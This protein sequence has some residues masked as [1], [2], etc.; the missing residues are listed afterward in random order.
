MD[1]TARRRAARRPALPEI[2]LGAGVA[3]AAV[4]ALWQASVIPVSPLYA[5]VGPTVFPYIGAVLLGILGLSLVYQGLRGGWQLPDEKEVPLDWRAMGVVGA[6]LLANVVMIQPLGF[7][8]ASTVMFTLIA[9][10]FGSRRPWIDAPIGLVLALAAYF[11]FAQG[12][13]VNIGRGPFE[14]ALQSA[15]GL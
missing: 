1:G 12:L 13:G 5:K 15:L 4:V 6:G 7:T 10:G 11:G 9:W 3:A 14:A 8:I 2:L